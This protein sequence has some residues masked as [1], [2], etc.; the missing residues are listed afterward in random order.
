MDSRAVKHWKQNPLDPFSLSAGK[1]SICFEL[2]LIF[3]SRASL[4]L[5]VEELPEHACSKIQPQAK[6][7]KQ[8][9]KQNKSQFF[10]TEK[11]PNNWNTSSFAN[12]LA[13]STYILFILFTFI[14]TTYG[15]FTMFKG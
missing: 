6:Q 3:A 5:C 1:T 7:K 9:I 4:S 10:K 15:K 8:K 11:L 12:T 14:S 13:R 2:Y